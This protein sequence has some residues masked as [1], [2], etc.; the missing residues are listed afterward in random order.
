MGRGESNHGNRG[1]LARGSFLKGEGE[2]ESPSRG[3]PAPGDD[4]DDV[5]WLDGENG[6]GELEDES[7]FAPES[8]SAAVAHEEGE[9]SF[10]ENN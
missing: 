7:I 4:G 8:G 3:T 2:G 5:P 10:L 9:A 1:A 6:N